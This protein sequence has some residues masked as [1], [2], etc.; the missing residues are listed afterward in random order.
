MLFLI[1]KAD[2]LSEVKIGE[3]GAWISRRKMGLNSTTRMIS[4]ALWRYRNKYLL[5]KKQNGAFIYH[6]AFLLFTAS[7]I[8]SEHAE[9]SK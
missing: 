8:L 6:M 4:R 3:L 2:P 1:Y 7:Y 9:R 5:P